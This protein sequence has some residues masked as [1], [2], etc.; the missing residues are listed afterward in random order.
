MIVLV[1]VD[2]LFNDWTPLVESKGHGDDI[3][4]PDFGG[5][6]DR[7]QTR[8]SSAVPVSLSEGTHVCYALLCH[9]A[10]RHLP[11]SAALTAFEDLGH[12]NT[13]LGSHVY[14]D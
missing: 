1:V 6:R 5:V 13:G 4:L 3:Y 14:Q 12:V 7:L 11:L 2:S 10:R 9:L 8:V